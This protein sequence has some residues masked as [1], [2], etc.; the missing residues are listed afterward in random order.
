VLR[1]RVFVLPILC[2]LCSCT[3]APDPRVARERIIREIKQG[4]LN[5]ALSDARHA[6]EQFAA[7]SPEWD[8]RFRILNA[9]ILVSR[10]SPREALAVLKGELPASL[11]STDIAVRKALYEGFAYRYLQQFPQAQERLAEAEKL[12]Q[13]IQPQLLCQVLI[14]KAGLEFDQE[15]FASAETDYT[16]AVALAKQYGLPE[17]QA[18]AENDLG[19]ISEKRERLDEAV[20]RYQNALASARALKMAALEATILGNLGWAYSTLGDYQNALQFYKQGADISDHIGLNGYSAYWY[21]GVANTYMALHQYAQ[22][23]TLSTQ[24]LAR[25]RRMGDAEMQT[26]TEC[27]NTLAEVSLRTGRLDDAEKYNREAV[28]LE[29]QGLD[30]FG[31]RE[32]TLVSGRI[33]TGRKNFA[34]AEKL[35]HQVS[36]DPAA[37]TA[38]K[39][40]L[41]ARLAELYDAEEKPAKAEQEFRQSI[42]TITAARDSIDRDDSRLSYLSSGIEFYDDYVDFLVRRNRPLDAL[43]VAETSRARMLLEG[44]SVDQKSSTRAIPLVQPQQLAK[45][46]QATLLFYWVGQDHSYLWA[47]TPAKTQCFEI[48]KASDLDPLAASYSKTIR[49]LRDPQGPGSA[50]GQQLYTTL[51]APAQQL[52]PKDG[53]IILLADPSLSALNFESLIVPGTSPHFW[54]EDVTLSNAS[55]LTLLSSAAA[56]PLSKENNLLLIGNTEPVEAFPALPE[57]PEEMRRVESFFPPAKRAVLEGKQATPE[58][59]L[60]S[61]PERYA[62]LHFVTHGTAS[63]TRP[64]DSAVILSKSGDSYKLYA[65]DILQHPL[66]AEL[67]TISACEGAAGRAYSGEGLIGLSWA[68]LRAGAHNVVG[69]LWEV[70]DSAAPQIMDTFYSEMSKGKD[71][72]SALRTAKL[73]LLHNQDPEIVFKKPFYWAPFQLYTGS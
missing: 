11:S 38:L 23:E 39:W 44:L 15:K 64:L 45:R 47:I 51:V 27:L 68:F 24:A 59:F 42:E 7:L 10:S 13:T 30:H 65:R 37:E 8:W 43:R 70:N 5:T 25:A 69:A 12:A 6:S 2:L 41:H 9:Q 63:I 54:I 20:D 48:P 17:Q 60:S 4:D 35:F 31:V 67:V 19:L 40:E 3:T 71:P 29:Q 62:Y 26:V 28:Q 57:A 55:S 56:R 14:A 53:R 52:L 66:S 49:D 33:E 72:A 36:A 18:N 16:R 61:H 34:Q 21:G 58:A 73:T 46:L 50:Q 32:S 1:P 22:A